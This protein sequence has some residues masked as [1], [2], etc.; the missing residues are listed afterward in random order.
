MQIDYSLSSHK[1]PYIEGSIIHMA[2]RGASEVHVDMDGFVAIDFYVY[3]N[4]EIEW[5]FFLNGVPVNWLELNDNH[6]LLVRVNAR[7]Y[8]GIKLSEYGPGEYE[9]DRYNILEGLEAA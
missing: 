2:N 7:K 8:F 5:Y 3:A 1:R 9:D 6:R 4:D